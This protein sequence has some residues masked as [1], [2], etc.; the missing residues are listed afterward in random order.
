MKYSTA[1]MM[2]NTVKTGGRLTELAAAAD[3][4][5]EG[6]AIKVFAQIHQCEEGIQDARLHFVGQVQ[7][8][9]RSPRQHFAVFRDVT[10]DLDLARVRGLSVNGFPAHLGA[11]G[12]N[13][14]GEM[15]HAQVN[16]LESRR[17]WSLAPFFTARR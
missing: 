16:R 1:G 12:F 11:I 6:G 13:L 10:N 14:Q 9:G 17:H 5:A 3:R 7:P 15:E 4:L 2:R 8:A